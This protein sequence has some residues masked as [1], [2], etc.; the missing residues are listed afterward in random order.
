MN[1]KHS[2]GHMVRALERWELLELLQVMMAD[3]VF[4]GV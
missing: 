4:E 2:D 3:G 1:A